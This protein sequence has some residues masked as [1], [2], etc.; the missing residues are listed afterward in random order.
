MVGDRVSDTIGGPLDAL[1]VAVPHRMALV[2]SEGSLTRADF[3]EKVARWRGVIGARVP[4]GSDVALAMGNGADLVA[5]FFACATWGNAA[6]VY[7]LSW[8]APYRAAIEAALSPPLTLMSTP[9]SLAEI[10][11][12]GFF[13]SIQK[14]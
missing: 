1:A 2:S 4:T 14:S 8:P 10:M 6:L 7:D 11:R 5:A 3:A 12:F 13:G 9:P